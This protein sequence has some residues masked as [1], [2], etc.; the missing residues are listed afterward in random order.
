MGQLASIRQSTGA[1]RCLDCGKCTAVC[2]LAAEGGF[3]ARLIAGQDLEDEIRGRGVGVG[4]CLTCAACQEYCPQ[5]VHFIDFVRGLRELIPAQARRP[6]PHAGIFQAAARSMAGPC[7]PRRDHDWVG[8]DLDVAEEGEVALFVGCLP[9]FDITFE[10]DL[11]IRTL[12]IARAAIRLL[13]HQGIK[14]VL[15]NDER[16]CGHDLLWSG[17]REIFNALARANAASFASRGVKKILT[18]CAECYRTWRLDYPDAAPTYRPQVQ[19]MAEFLA[20]RAA[21]GELSFREDGERKLT[22]QDPCRL[23][24]HMGVVDEPRQ[25]MNAMPGVELAEMSRSGRNAVCCGTSGFIHCDA[26]SRRLQVER[27]A[28]ARSTGAQTL[29]TSCPKCLIHFACAQTEDERLKKENA[30]IEI[31]DFTVLAADRL[32]GER[33]KAQAQPVAA[34]QEAGVTR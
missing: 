23:G 17:D 18:T 11:G 19:H 27:L 21:A 25:V 29:I 28:S 16:C 33:E 32:K 12:D 4:R 6:C 31:K 10:E 34:G 5:N 3:S 30:R 7:A 1:S 8:P 2:P 15:V 9:Y 22:Y 24:R 13:N 26:A 14:P 20:P